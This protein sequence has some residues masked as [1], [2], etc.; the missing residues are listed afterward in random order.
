[1]S[2]PENPAREAVEEAQRAAALSS[3]RSSTAGTLN[4]TGHDGPPRLRAVA[5]GAGPQPQPKPQPGEAHR[6]TPMPAPEILPGPTPMSPRRP[7]P[8]DARPTAMERA[9]HGLRA[10]LPLVQKVLPLLEGQVFTV[11]S[12][13]LAAPHPAPPPPADLSPLEG[14]LADMRTRH[15]E[16]FNQVLQQNASLKRLAERL[17]QVQA[18]ADRNALEQ[19]DLRESLRSVARRANG[20][21]IAALCLL[22]ASLAANLFLFLHF[23]RILH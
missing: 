13:L 16:L 12:N 6:A 1:M 18:A 11:L 9:M 8:A 2:E 14:S 7:D 21:A 17:E 20:I 4:P 22:A 23:Q 5:A 3:A 15:M 19:K 10:A